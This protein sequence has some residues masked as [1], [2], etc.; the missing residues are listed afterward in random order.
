MNERYPGYDVLAKRHSPSCDDQTR[1]V[2]DERLAIEPESRG[3]C[4]EP[5]WL[6]LKAVC[7][8]IIPQ[9]GRR[10]R[11]AP[12]A[13]MIDRKLRDGPGDGYRDPRLPSAGDAWRRGLRALDAEAMA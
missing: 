6:T 9:P 12:L 5:E 13:A 4:T 3:F 7:G 2:I 10:V 8:R 1:R 11:P